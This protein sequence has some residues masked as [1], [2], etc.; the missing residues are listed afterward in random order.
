MN[1]TELLKALGLGFEDAAKI[2]GVRRQTLYE[3]VTAKDGRSTAKRRGGSR[4]QTDNAVAASYL[5][6]DRLL[7]IWN[8]FASR[9][10]WG[11]AN[12]VRDALVARHPKLEK[13]VAPYEVG[14][15][16]SP[17]EFNF[18]EVW[19]F[20]REPIEIKSAAFR[21]EMSKPLKDA[22]KKLVYF[23]PSDEIA[24]RLLTVLRVAAD[25]DLKKVFIVVTNAVLLCP[26]TVVAF[27]SSK[28]G[29][30]EVMAGVMPEPPKGTE[31][32]KRVVRLP[33]K[34]DSDDVQMNYFK[35]VCDTLMQAGLL[36]AGD[37]FKLPV[38]PIVGGGGIPQFKIFYP[39]TK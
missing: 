34:A 1:D 15:T 36:D 35:D 3:G 26:H 20:S 37:R 18:S 8:S 14:G 6:A 30:D 27:V 39:E 32:W 24:A 29:Q 5:N 2:I 28:D 9:E 31:V 7:A 11:R 17:S 38:T 16:D 19:I 25:G 33:M 13:L 4:S 23:V 12:I 10:D 22:E 21:R